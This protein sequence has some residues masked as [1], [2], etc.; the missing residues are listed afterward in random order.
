MQNHH[1]DITRRA[2]A[3]EEPEY[4]VSRDGEAPAMK[5]CQNQSFRS[6]WNGRPLGTV[7]L[8][9]TALQNSILRP[10]L[11]LF[12]LQDFG[13]RAPDYSTMSRKRLVG[14]RLDMVR[15]SARRTG[16]LLERRGASD[17]EEI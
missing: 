13:S 10:A 9:T 14:C 5:A 11:I 17:R 3:H 12:S 7:N 16:A 8:T 6:M 1:T 4:N 15:L 2:I